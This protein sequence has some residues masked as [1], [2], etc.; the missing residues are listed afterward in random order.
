MGIWK[1]M[2]VTAEPE[3]TLVEWRI[4]ETERGERHFVGA[5][6]DNRTSRVSS[7]IV[8]FDPKRMMGVSSSGRVYKL[9]GPPGWDEDVDYVW[10]VWR[11]M[12]KVS[13]YADVT[14]AT[15]RRPPGGDGHGPQAISGAQT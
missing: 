2:P 14:D 1:C 8:G 5:R 7:A 10:S 3:V 11:L 9:L 6:V 12:Y 4:M 15:L 13:S